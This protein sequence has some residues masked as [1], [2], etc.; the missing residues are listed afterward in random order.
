M[1]D[2]VIPLIMGLVQRFDREEKAE[3][4]YDYAARRLEPTDDITFPGSK[5]VLI[6][7]RC[8]LSFGSLAMLARGSSMGSKR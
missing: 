4:L 8:Q 1:L 3:T 5:A 2:R 7:T 6:L